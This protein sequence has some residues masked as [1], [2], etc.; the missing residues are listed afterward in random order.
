VTLLRLPAPSL[1]GTFA[2]AYNLLARLVSLI[3]W[4]ELLKCRSQV[5]VMEVSVISGW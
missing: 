2:K 3:G 1:R 4:D 5:F